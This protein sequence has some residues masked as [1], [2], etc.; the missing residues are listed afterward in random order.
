MISLALLAGPGFS[1]TAGNSDPT[2]FLIPV[3][4]GTGGAGGNHI[5]YLGL[6]VTRPVV[7]Q[8]TA[9]VIGTNTITDSG[10]NWVTDQ[11]AG[12]NPHF[13][14]ITSVSGSTTATGVGTTYR[15]VSNTSTTVT[16]ASNLASGIA[17][18][19]G[20][21]VRK[22]WTIASVFGP[23][24]ESGLQGGTATT[25][26][27]VQLWNGTSLDSYYY[28]TSG[29]T[30]W[31][32]VGDTGTDAG[33]TIIP[34]YSAVLVVRQQ[35]ENLTFV[36]NGTVKTGQTAIPIVLGDNYVGNIYPA[37]LTLATSGLYTGSA[38]TGLVGG[39]S[40][41]ADQVQIWNGAS[42]DIYYYQTVGA[43][44]TGWRRVGAPSVDA[45]N[46][47][48]AENSSLIIKRRNNGAFNWIVPETL[49]SPGGI[50]TPTPSTTPTSTPGVTPSPTPVVTP[51]PGVT[52]SPTPVASASPTPGV[53][54]SP[55]A[56]P[57]SQP[58]N[59]STRMLVQT[60]DN[61]GIGGFIITGNAPKDVLLRAIGPS[62]EQ[63]GVLDALADPV[64]ELHGPGGFVVTDDNW[65]DDPAQETAIVATGIPPTNELESAIYA[66][67]NPGAYTAVVR[68][69]NDTSGVA[70]VEVYDV[71][72]AVTAQLAN[73]ST[74]A[75][76]STGSNVVIAGFIL[77][78]NLG[79]D[80]IVL[81]GI[82]PSLSAV[83]VSNVLADPTLELRN[84]SGALLFTNNDWQDD[85]TQIADLNV[86][87]LAPSNNLE[88]ALVVTLPPGEYTALLA[89]VN[90][91]SG[92]GLVEVYDLP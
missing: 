14:E 42:F 57:A 83:G 16:L 19:V 33:G 78:N 86:A 73:I 65:R 62:L 34:F 50:S 58:I 53:S 60:G 12:G 80:R 36:L 71:R 63:S 11:F 55:T 52:P 32:R 35:S 56:T 13:V 47:V 51:T 29:G 67:L 40:S 61:A 21:K 45:G 68:G 31:R 79:H 82:G 23:N 77:G 30:G 9:S 27:L 2:G 90:N 3:V 5:T 74:R 24:D 69:K 76:V 49:T 88:S 89:G 72:Q 7:Y 10:A 18:P 25:A 46:T 37:N 22:E 38:A 75:F 48:I 41:T 43:G 17:A 81:R 92:V 28:Q 20:Y 87:G 59:L 39:D 91:G 70:L 64:L 44:G 4:V 85:P 6:G 15:I 26:D 1:Q 84:S 66:T 54:P 8:N